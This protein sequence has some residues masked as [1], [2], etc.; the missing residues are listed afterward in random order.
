MA[1]Y[2]I[3]TWY[4]FKIVA[5]V[6]AQTA[7][8]YINGTK[9]ITTLPLYT[10]AVEDIGSIET[11]TPGSNTIDQYLDNISITAVGGT[12]EVPVPA[13]P[14]GLTA[15]AGNGQVALAWTAVNDATGYNIKRSTTSGSGY[16]QVGTSETASY[17]DSG[18]TNGTAYYYVVEAVNSAGKSPA[19]VEASATPTAPAQAPEAP[20]GLTAAAG[21]GQVALAWTA[22]NDV[23][24]YNIKRSTVSGSGYTQVGTSETAS[25]TDSGLTNGTTYYYV[26]EA[27]NSAGTSP[28]SVEASATPTAPAQAPEAPTGL[29]AAAGNGQVALAWTAVNGAAGYNIKRSTVSGSGYTQ[30]GTSETASY[31]DSG[32]TNGTTYYYAVEAVNSAGTSPVSVEA[33]ATPTAP[34][35]APEAPTGLTAAAGNGQVALAWTA[36]NGAAGYNIK[37]S[38]VSGSGYTQVGTSETA[39]YTDSGLTNGTTYYY[40]VEAVNSAGKSPASVEAS[41]TPTASVTITIP[42]VTASVYATG[43]SS[44][45]DITWATVTGATYY[46][47]KR[48]MSA[49]GPFTNIATQLTANSYA[50]TNVTNGTTYYYVVT[51][52]NEVGE[53]EA[54]MVASATPVNSTN[55]NRSGGGSSVGAT[56]SSTVTLNNDGSVSISTTAESQKTTDGKTAAVVTLDS[57]T[58]DQAINT[59]TSNNH[60]EVVVEVKGDGTVA[61]VILPA[62]SLLNA[63]KQSSDM[64]LV[65]KFNNATYAL[66]MNLLNIDSL[67]KS[68]GADV[69][70]VK[71]SIVIEQVSG[72]LAIQIANAAKQAGAQLLTPAVDF[73]VTVEAN[74]KS[75]SVN[76]FGSTY[77]S[78]TLELSGTVDSKQATAVM[79]DPASGEMTF[80]PATFQAADGKTK[81]TI[82]R[83]GNSIYSVVQF[84]KSF[85]DMKD[86]WAKDDVE[87]LASKLLVKGRTE[88]AFDPQSSISRAEFAALL[89]RGL[90]LGEDKSNKFKD[91]SANDWYMGIVGAAAKAGLI[92]GDESGKFN[93]NAS[94]TREEMA[95][96]IN[97]AMAFAG[98]KT[99]GDANR[100]NAFKDAG[101]ISA[102]AK[103]AVAK[104]VTAGLL[105]GKSANTFEPSATANRAEAAVLLKRLLQTERFIN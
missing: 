79:I 8:V 70:D 26:V 51:A 27:V 60:K 42:S 64:V 41:A 96:M 104:G 91:V 80:V 69:K 29:T 2:A 81:V 23:T 14:T 93:P 12:P 100:L 98:D 46:N 25:Y 58:L 44:R 5:D 11:L 77:V 15:A 78:R 87:L 102:W 31:T 18:L 99:S 88:T 32:L 97:R 6:S 39:S 74:G 1:G 59:S 57:A 48:S 9:Q 56:S 43:A 62:S 90:G 76:D 61:Q 20:T 103:D 55:R 67:A 101:A 35:Q 82:S 30:V 10:A 52:A 54:S 95:V 34:A 71:V 37:R 36:V 38:T 92:E 4:H 84:S 49:S 22:V 28:V 89:V 17:T 50:D 21:N 24:G 7:D 85:A 65:V 19:S 53:S 45:V 105:N 40:V 86:H 33:S 3:N 66:P 73:T 16:T 68:I 72:S 94:I 47:V 13:S 75:A 83:P 63:S